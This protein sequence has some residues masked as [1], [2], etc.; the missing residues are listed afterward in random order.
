MLGSFF[1]P[2]MEGRE[3]TIQQA[4]LR[5]H[6][7]AVLFSICSAVFSVRVTR[8]SQCDR[9]TFPAV[10][11]CEFLI[12]ESITQ[13]AAYFFKYQW[14]QALALLFLSCYLWKRSKG[15]SLFF[16]LMRHSLHFI[17]LHSNFDA[18]KDALLYIIY[19][20]ILLSKSKAQ[21]L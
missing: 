8:N 4:R 5:A 3:R 14:L 21:L 12:S 11:P 18:E 13:S 16:T 2:S 1:Y 20:I 9:V 6:D 17:S 10:L 19:I 15:E 7:G